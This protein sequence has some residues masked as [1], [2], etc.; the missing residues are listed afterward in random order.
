MYKSMYKLEWLIEEV[1]IVLYYTLYGLKCL[2]LLLYIQLILRYVEV[3][4]WYIA[5]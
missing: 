3:L 2:L 4:T 1:R 5:S